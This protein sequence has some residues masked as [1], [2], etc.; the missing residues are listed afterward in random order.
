MLWV[1]LTGVQIEI[2]AV[3][4]RFL[5]RDHRSS[6]LVGGACELWWSA[7]PRCVQARGYWLRMNR[8]A[9]TWPGGSTPGQARTFVMRYWSTFKLA[10]SF[11]WASNMI[12]A[13]WVTPAPLTMS[14]Q[15]GLDMLS[16]N[17][18]G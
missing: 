7:G 5:N 12:A 2:D 15:A 11:A 6:L 1:C 13:D 14:V 17:G 18:G 3:L 8:D 9:M 16:L 10:I 4:A